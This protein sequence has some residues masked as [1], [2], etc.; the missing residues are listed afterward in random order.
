MFPRIAFVN[1]P[2]STSGG[3]ANEIREPVGIDKL[4]PRT[5]GDY[6]FLCNRSGH[7]FESFGKMA[8]RQGQ[9]GVEQRLGVTCK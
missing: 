3:E 8:S 2:R 9:H 6:Q 5:A 1:E 4:G 7:L